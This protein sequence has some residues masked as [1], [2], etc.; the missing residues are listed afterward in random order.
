MLAVESLVLNQVMLMGQTQ[1]QLMV[2]SQQFEDIRGK[3]LT[4]LQASFTF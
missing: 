1:I 3:L 4:D 2:I